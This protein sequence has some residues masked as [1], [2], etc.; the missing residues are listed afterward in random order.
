[1]VGQ[2]LVGESPRAGEAAPQEKKAD[3]LE[4]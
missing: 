2:F 4:G 3:A 1:V